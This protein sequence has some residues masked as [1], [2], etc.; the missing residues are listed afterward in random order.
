MLALAHNHCDASALLLPPVTV[1]A[2]WQ[3]AT[4]HQTRAMVIGVTGDYRH[5]PAAFVLK[6]RTP[7]QACGL[8]AGGFVRDFSW[9]WSHHG[10]GDAFG[11][12]CCAGSV[13][14]QPPR[15]RPFR[16]TLDAS[17]QHTSCPIFR[18]RVYL[19]HAQVPVLVA[20]GHGLTQHSIN[21][22]PSVTNPTVLFYFY[23]GTLHQ[24]QR[25]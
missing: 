14:P 5:V 16:R 9:R 2:A 11:T 23:C 7:L 4:C 3:M 8:C 18:S 6:L 17:Y 21:I 20:L 24:Q 13:F 25:K 19:T 22:R 12:R 10:H 1:P 15:S